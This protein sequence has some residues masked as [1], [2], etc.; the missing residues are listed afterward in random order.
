MYLY[1]Y[2]ETALSLYPSFRPPT[3]PAPSITP[4]LF[5]RTSAIISETLPVFVKLYAFE[6][7]E[8]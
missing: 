4:K 3:F 6:G 8:S 5:E 2:W 7:E 1:V